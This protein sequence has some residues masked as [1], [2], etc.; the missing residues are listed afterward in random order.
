MVEKEKVKWLEVIT[1][2]LPI[3]YSEGDYQGRR[4]G[5]TKSAFNNGKSFKVYAEE[6]GGKDFI[7][8]NLYLTNEGAVLK[9]CEMP[10][11][12]VKSFLNEVRRR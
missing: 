3:G 6:L 12:K 8:L 11:Q 5:I 2:E 1:T 10:E 9:P 4:Y 7:S